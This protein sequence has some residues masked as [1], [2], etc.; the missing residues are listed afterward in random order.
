MGWPLSNEIRSRVVNRP[1]NFMLRLLAK[2]YDRD[3]RKCAREQLSYLLVKY[4][5][6]KHGDNN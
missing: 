5:H 6:T 2:V 3:D 4:Q 1:K